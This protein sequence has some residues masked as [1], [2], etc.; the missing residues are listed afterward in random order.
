[1]VDA[2][3]KQRPNPIITGTATVAAWGLLSL[4]AFGLLL[5]LRVQNFK[6]SATTSGPWYAYPT[7]HLKF[8]LDGKSE[9]GNYIILSINRSLVSSEKVGALRICFGSLK[10]LGLSTLAPANKAAPYP[11]RLLRRFQN[12]G[13]PLPQPSILGNTSTGAG[14]RV[15]I[16][17]NFASKNTKLQQPG[18]LVS[19]ISHP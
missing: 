10:E 6:L 12:L 4:M 15:C 2:H 1:M 17:S 16:S 14:K 7:L 5:Q 8:D 11:T 19:S 9:G 3:G 18:T 13:C